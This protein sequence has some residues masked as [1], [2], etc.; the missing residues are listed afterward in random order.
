M[1][2]EYKVLQCFLGSSRINI[3]GSVKNFFF[4]KREWLKVLTKC[5]SKENGFLVFVTRKGKWKM[6]ET[7]RV[8]HILQSY[9]RNLFR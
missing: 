5:N 7:D 8:L 3:L 2:M 6:K 1:G 4:K 9:G